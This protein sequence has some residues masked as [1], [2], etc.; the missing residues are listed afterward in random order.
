MLPF[1]TIFWYKFELSWG[2][3]WYYRKAKKDT[4]KIVETLPIGN[5]YN[6]DPNVQSAN[7]K[8]L[9]SFSFLTLSNFVGYLTQLHKGIRSKDETA[10]TSANDAD[11]QMAL[12]SNSNLN[13]RK[14][15]RM[16]IMMNKQEIILSYKFSNIK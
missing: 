16:N 1:D 7:D 11:K 10:E 5:A 13:A 4:W 2:R 3:S 15:K 9:T 6:V 14:N 8:I 12:Q